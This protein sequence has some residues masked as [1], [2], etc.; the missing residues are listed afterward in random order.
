MQWPNLAFVIRSK[1]RLAFVVINKPF[2][3][4]AQQKNVSA[5]VTALMSDQKFPDSVRV[6]LGLASL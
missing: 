6:C 4:V 1:S 3:E 5:G 2:S